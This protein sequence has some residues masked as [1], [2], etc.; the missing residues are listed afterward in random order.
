M[1]AKRAVTSR[2]LKTNDSDGDIRPNGRGRNGY[3]RELAGV[4]DVSSDDEVCHGSVA[5]A[6]L[7]DSRPI[8][9]AIGLYMYVAMAGLS[10]SRQIATAQFVLLIA[11]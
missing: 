5:V 7:H 11:N 1:M 10:G 3:Y 6:I 8:Y 2:Y 4:Y 9:V